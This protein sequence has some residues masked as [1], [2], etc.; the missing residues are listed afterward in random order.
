[1]TSS[2]REAST[3]GNDGQRAQPPRSRLVRAGWTALGLMLVG[4]GALGIVLPGLPTTPFLV[5][6]AACFARS[7]PR[8]YGW[9]L[10]HRVFGPWI[11]DYRAGR[12]LPRRVAYGAI[13]TMWVFVLIALTLALPAGR[14]VPRVV[15]AA[16]AVIGTL[17]LLRLARLSR[18]YERV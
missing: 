7:S 11:R 12:G 14:I 15:V 10:G 17:Y 3:P 8:L 18:T 16:A 2:S 9:L 13:A 4:V 6:A 5:L 1:M